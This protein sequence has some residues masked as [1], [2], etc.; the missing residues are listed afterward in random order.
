MFG[1]EVASS[2]SSTSTAQA[3]KVG[4]QSMPNLD[5]STSVTNIKSQKPWQ[6][7]HSFF[8]SS[9][10]QGTRVHKKPP[11]A[12]DLH[13]MVWDSSFGLTGK[14]IEERQIQPSKVVPR[15]PRDSRVISQHFHPKFLVDIKGASPRGSNIK[16]PLMDLKVFLSSRNISTFDAHTASDETNSYP[17]PPSTKPEQ[18]CNMPIG[19]ASL[20]AKAY[21]MDEAVQSLPDPNSEGGHK[22]FSKIRNQRLPEGFIVPTEAFAVKNDLAPES[23]ISSN[24]ALVRKRIHVADDLALYNSVRASLEAIS[25]GQLFKY[26]GPF[27][28]ELFKDS[29]LDFKWNP[30]QDPEMKAFSSFSNGQS[31]DRSNLPLDVS[32]SGFDQTWRTTKSNP[33]D[34]ADLCF[35]VDGS[36]DLAEQ[37]LPELEQSL[38]SRSLRTTMALRVGCMET[39][40]DRS[41]ISIAGLISRIPVPI[42]LSN[43][44]SGPRDLIFLECFHNT[45][46][47]LYSS[48]EVKIKNCQ[49]RYKGNREFLAGALVSI[50]GLRD[51]RRSDELRVRDSTHSIV[52]SYSTNTSKT[53][54]AC[55]KPDFL[56]LRRPHK[57]LYSFFHKHRLFH[58]CG[59]LCFC[60]T[61]NT[62]SYRKS[63]R[64]E[65]KHLAKM[66]EDLY[67]ASSEGQPSIS[68]QGLPYDHPKPGQPGFAV[69]VCTPIIYNRGEQP[70]TVYERLRESEYERQRFWICLSSS[71]KAKLAEAQEA[72]DL[73]GFE[74]KYNS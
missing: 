36:Y 16:H 73:Q 38:N 26:N 43:L 59:L 71:M 40:E 35:L 5:E 23:T 66:E 47:K 20:S 33:K 61:R 29:G 2:S 4:Y 68:N 7:D 3:A 12:A 72:G 54:S 62:F 17:N 15:Y 50:S 27:T 24:A 57:Q 6:I 31:Q 55:T 8:V 60:F 65:L 70:D 10:S 37:C 64:F 21:E 52:L 51:G 11:S 39:Y 9:L 14:M 48:A 56:S 34:L 1:P 58:L 28:N 42:I 19:Y 30:S 69:W 67:S 41:L 63:H 25:H 13:K 44:R 22:Y 18:R 49:K 74:A 46:A 53:S 45:S 32:S